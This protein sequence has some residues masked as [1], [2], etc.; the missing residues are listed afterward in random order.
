MIGVLWAIY[1]GVATVLSD[2]GLFKFD[3]FFFFKEDECAVEPLSKDHLFRI[4]SV[5]V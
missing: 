3:F 1:L 4:F 2:V 5:S